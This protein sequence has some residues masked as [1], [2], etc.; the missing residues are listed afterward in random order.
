VFIIATAG[1]DYGQSRAKRPQGQ[2]LSA[3]FSSEK[4]VLFTWDQAAS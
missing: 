3:S 1:G 4:E 2:S